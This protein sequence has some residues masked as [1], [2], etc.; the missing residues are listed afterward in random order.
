MVFLVTA[1]AHHGADL[2]LPMHTCS[3]VDKSNTLVLVGKYDSMHDH[4]N[5]DR[6]VPDGVVCRWAVLYG[7]TLA[8]DDTPEPSA[9]PHAAA[10]MYRVPLSP[11]MY[12]S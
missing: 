10:S 1:T 4:N 8:A 3:M 5:T 11:A 12:W 6:D 7:C 2:R 9:T